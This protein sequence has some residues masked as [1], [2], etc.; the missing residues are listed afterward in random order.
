MAAEKPRK[1]LLRMMREAG[2]ARANFRVWRTLDLSKGDRKRMNAMNDWTYVDFF[3]VAIWGTQV[4]AFLSL[5]KIFDQT[6]GALKLQDVVRSLDDDELSRDVD[7]L[8]NEHGKA[9]EKIKRIRDKAVAHNQRNM[10][11]RSLFDHVGITPNELESLIENLCRI[12]NG[13][14]RRE[15]SPTEFRMT[16]AFGMPFMVFWTSW[17]TTSWAAILA[18]RRWRRRNKEIS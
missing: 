5:G 9:I 14:A 10:D 12:L 11:E 17:E 6:K 8:Y 13:A 15:S 3:H 2:D 4:L 7:A 1:E 18:E 16:Y